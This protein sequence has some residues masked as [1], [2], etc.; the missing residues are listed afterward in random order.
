MIVLAVFKHFLGSKNWEE[1]CQNVSENIFWFLAQPKFIC[2]LVLQKS[3]SLLKLIFTASDLRQRSKLYWK[4]L[5]CTVASCKNLLLK[6]I[7]SAAG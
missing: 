1:N 6:T 5:F 3:H 7:P 2:N 4:P